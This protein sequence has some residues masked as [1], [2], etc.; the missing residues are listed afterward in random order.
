MLLDAAAGFSAS[1]WLAGDGSDLVPV[2]TLSLTT[3]FLAPAKAGRVAVT[4]QTTGGGG[5]TVFAEATLR[6]ADGE[7]CSTAAGVFQRVRHGG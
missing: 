4:G 7:I 5:R 2:V 1:R 3:S 6:D